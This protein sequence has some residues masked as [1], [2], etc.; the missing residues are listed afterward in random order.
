MDFARLL[1]QPPAVTQQEDLLKR[2]SVPN[3]NVM[4]FD[5][6]FRKKNSSLRLGKKI[7]EFYTA[8][9]T[10]FWAHTVSTCALFRGVE[11][12]VE[13]LTW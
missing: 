2:D 9:V 1:L 7:Y 6:T 13:W 3:G 11:G 4:T 5:I 12:R 10:K 8:P